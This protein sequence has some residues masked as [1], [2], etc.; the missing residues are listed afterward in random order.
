MKEENDDIWLVM[1][2]L[3]VKYFFWEICGEVQLS[4]LFIVKGYTVFF[5]G[6]FIIFY[7]QFFVI[8]YCF[9]FGVFWVVW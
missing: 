6:I 9:F 4:F 2:N 8:D 7:F 5:G 3:R 1:N